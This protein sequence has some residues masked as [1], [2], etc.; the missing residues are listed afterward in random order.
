MAQPVEESDAVGLWRIEQVAART[1]LTK[2]TLR[3]YEEIGLVV[4]AA[5]TEGNYRMYSDA[6]VARIERVCQLKSLG[7]S[8]AEITAMLHAEDERAEIRTAFYN[9]RSPTERIEQLARA[10][11]LVHSQIAVIDAKLRAVLEVR[12]ALRERLKA[13]A[14]LRAEISG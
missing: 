7:L 1:G 10:E 13:I 9:T 14:R 2:R 6:D 12:D 3:Y 11:E 4:P 8:L 5:R